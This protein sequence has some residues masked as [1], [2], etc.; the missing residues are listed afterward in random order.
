MY[1]AEFQAR[2]LLSGILEHE[3]YLYQC[4]VLDAFRRI[5]TLPDDLDLL[6]QRTLHD[7]AKQR[8]DAAPDFLDHSPWFDRAR[9]NGSTPGPSSPTG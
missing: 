7:R 4:G 5:L 2:P 8:A 1:L 9:R 3:K 6:Q